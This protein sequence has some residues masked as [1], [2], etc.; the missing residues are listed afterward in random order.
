MEQVMFK[1]KS[2]PQNFCGSDFFKHYLCG[3]F[4]TTFLPFTI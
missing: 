3:Y 1:K 4:T 2:L